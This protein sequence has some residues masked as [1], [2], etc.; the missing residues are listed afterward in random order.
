MYDITVQILEQ[1]DQ[2][3]YGNVTALVKKL[4]RELQKLSEG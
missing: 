3:N 2:H 4:Q 1:L